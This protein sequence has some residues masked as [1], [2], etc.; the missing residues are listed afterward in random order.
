MNGRNM[1]EHCMATF[2][3]DN[4]VRKGRRLLFFRDACFVVYFWKIK[5]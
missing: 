2:L 5:L 4:I 1:P 3:Y